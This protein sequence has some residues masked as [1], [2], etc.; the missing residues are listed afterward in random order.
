SERKVFLEYLRRQM[1]RVKRLQQVFLS[2]VEEH[3]E[4]V[5]LIADLGARECWLLQQIIEAHREHGLP[6]KGS[7]CA[8]R[9]IA[10]DRPPY[11]CVV[12][13]AHDLERRKGEERHANENARVDSRP[14][15]AP[16]F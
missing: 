11:S 8:D 12:G 3:P 16:G 2:S 1:R 13:N 4:A 6:E 10:G 15:A 5:D 9:K 7:D 14:H